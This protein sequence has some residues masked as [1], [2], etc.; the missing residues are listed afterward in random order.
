MPGTTIYRRI[1]VF[2]SQEVHIEA[3][4]GEWVRDDTM[5]TKP[6]SEIVNEWCKL[7]EVE[8]IIASA[9]QTEL[10]ASGKTDDGLPA[11]VYR[12]S[13]TVIYV[14][15]EIID[16]GQEAKIVREIDP[17]G[18]PTGLQE[19]IEAFNKSAG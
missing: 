9:P 5:S 19:V 13:L 17:T 6:I 15:E 2:H 3:Q 11:R 10:V 14:P 7:H 18:L 4:P 12:V 16:Y 8:P 1:G